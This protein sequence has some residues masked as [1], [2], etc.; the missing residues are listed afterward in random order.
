M[1]MEEMNECIWIKYKK[2]LKFKIQIQHKKLW[3]TMTNYYYTS[4][5]CVHQKWFFSHTLNCLVVLFCFFSLRWPMPSVCACVLVSLYLLFFAV[6]LSCCQ[7]MSGIWMWM[8]FIHLYM[9]FRC[10]YLWLSTNEIFFF[11]SI[12]RVRVT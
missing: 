5:L 7:S 3:I 10:V 2:N 11:E 12:L 6:L 9:S 8:S 4:K 1:H